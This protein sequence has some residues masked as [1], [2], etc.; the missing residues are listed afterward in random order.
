MIVKYEYGIVNYVSVPIGAGVSMVVDRWKITFVA[1]PDAA[2]FATIPVE[3]TAQTDI[4]LPVLVEV[5]SEVERRFEH[6]TPNP[7]PKTS[8]YPGSDLEIHVAD[9][10]V[11]IWAGWRNVHV[12]PTRTQDQVAAFIMG[13][14]HVINFCEQLDEIRV[15]HDDV[16]R[17]RAVRAEDRLVPMNLKALAKAAAAAPIPQTQD[18]KMQARM[19]AFLLANP[20]SGWVVARGYQTAQAPTL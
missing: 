15:H 8:F 7:T 17:Y 1:G 2:S 4:A 14:I 9:H 16:V 3:F 11:V 19:T 12:I 18:E 10:E 20:D 6:Q 13:L 5:T